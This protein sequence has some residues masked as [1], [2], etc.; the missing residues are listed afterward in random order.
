MEYYSAL[1][2]G[3]LT[4]ATAWMNLK[5]IMVNEINQSKKTLY[6]STYMRYLK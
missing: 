1:R 6:N 2:K 4:H 5:D 3:I